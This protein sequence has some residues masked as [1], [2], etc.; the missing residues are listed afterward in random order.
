MYP[1]FSW[2]FFLFSSIFLFDFTSNVFN[3][4]SGQECQ[5][6]VDSL[7]MLLTDFSSSQVGLAWPESWSRCVSTQLPIH[8]QH[9]LVC[10][11]L[12]KCTL[13]ISGSYRLWNTWHFGFSWFICLFF[14]LLLWMFC[15]YIITRSLMGFMSDGKGWRH[16]HNNNV[17]FPSS[18]GLCQSLNPFFKKNQ[19]NKWKY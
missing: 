10:L 2:F 12:H 4:N 13:L 9:Y 11:L 15:F 17:A 18:R 7:C 14:G 6:H 3:V 19:T 8:C 1:F 5:I 16:R